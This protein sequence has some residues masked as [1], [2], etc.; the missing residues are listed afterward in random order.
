MPDKRPS[1]SAL[2]ARGA[3]SIAELQRRALTCTACP[4][5]AHATQTVFGEGSSHAKLMLV[6]EQPGDEEDIKGH[7]FVGPAGRVLAEA[8]DDAGVERSAVYLTNA[9]KHFKFESKGDRRLHAR[10]KPGEIRACW[11][12]LESEIEILQPVVILCLGA[13]AAQAF[14]GKTFSV[15][16]SR[17]KVFDS[18]PWAPAWMATYHPAAIL[19][20]PDQESRRR[21]RAELYADIAKA[22]EIAHTKSAATSDKPRARPQSPS[23]GSRS[24]SRSAAR[25]A[26]TR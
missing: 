7:P 21:A 12:W 16:Q 1:E 22:W 10:P 5:Y 20:M 19:R 6:G 18:T 2:L 25:T 13:T 26:P 9:V 3:R 8:F 14:Q 15:T 11:G 4:L 23:A 17:G 24:R